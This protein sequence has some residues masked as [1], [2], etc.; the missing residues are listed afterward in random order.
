MAH[1]DRINESIDS[2]RAFGSAYGSASWRQGDGP[3]VSV[4]DLSFTYGGTERELSWAILF[5]RCRSASLPILPVSSFPEIDF[6]GGGTIRVQ[7]K[8][9]LEL[10]TTG[11]YHLNVYTTR[12]GD[13]SAVVACGDFRYSARG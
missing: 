6:T 8:L 9:S 2:V 10:P 3:E 13:E 5:G 4:V 7:A 1:E 12:T 11:Q